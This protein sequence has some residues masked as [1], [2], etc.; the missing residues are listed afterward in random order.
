[1]SINALLSIICRSNITML[2]ITVRQPTLPINLRI[3]LRGGCRDSEVYWAS[4]IIDAIPAHN[5]I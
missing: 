1:M 2:F 3:L 5:F 4:A